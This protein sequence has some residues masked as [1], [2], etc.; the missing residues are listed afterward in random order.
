MIITASSKI[1]TTR[2]F[3]ST[4]IHDWTKEEFYKTL[5]TDKKIDPIYTICLHLFKKGVC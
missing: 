4:T 5:V 2:W 1:E 3:T